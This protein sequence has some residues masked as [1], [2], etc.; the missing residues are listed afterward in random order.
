VP[1]RDHGSRSVASRAE[2]GWGSAPPSGD[3]AIRAPAGRRLAPGAGIQHVSG[4]IGLVPARQRP[5][6]G[7]MSSPIPFQDF[8]IHILAASHQP[9]TPAPFANRDSIVDAGFRPRPRQVN[10]YCVHPT[11]ARGDPTVRD[12][13][14]AA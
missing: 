4:P 2:T 14:Q 6:S 12:G 13:E 8:A 5:P 10:R 1:G 7:G 11:V 9:R 3:A